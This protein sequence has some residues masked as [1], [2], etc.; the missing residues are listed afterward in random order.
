MIG[1][2]IDIALVVLDRVCCKCVMSMRAS[3]SGLF[4]M[5]NDDLSLICGYK[6]VFTVPIEEYLEFRRVIRWIRW[7]IYRYIVLMKK[8]HKGKTLAFFRFCMIVLLSAK[9]TVPHTGPILRYRWT[10]RI[11]C[12]INADLFWWTKTPKRPRTVGFS[13]I[14]FLCQT[15]QIY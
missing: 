14:W 11:E 15:G 5:V 8:D 3:D 7:P 12:R 13:K 6:L 10:L 9:P 1:W 2:C 4:A